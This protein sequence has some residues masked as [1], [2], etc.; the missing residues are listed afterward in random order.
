M[1]RT[2]LAQP[3]RFFAL[4]AMC[5][6]LVGGACASD[7]KADK[8]RPEG[9]FSPRA[10]VDTLRVL[11]LSDPESDLLPHG[12]AEGG[13]YGGI[14]RTSALLKALR[15]RRGVP[16]LGLS[17]GDMYMPAPELSVDSGGQNAVAAANNS[18]GIEASALGNHEFDLGESFL[19]GM[20]KAA[21][22]TYLSST[23]DVRGGALASLYVADP[24]AHSPWLADH[25]GHI[26]P[27]GLACAGGDLTAGP[28]GKKAC[29]GLTVGVVGATTE[30]LRRLSKIS[31]DI[32]VPDDRAGVVARIQAAT[33]Q[34]TAQGA[35]IVVLLSHMQ[36]VRID[37]ELAKSLTG[38]DIIVSGGGDH[39]LAD[40]DDRLLPQHDPDP[41]CADH[42]D[43]CFP[44]I[45]QAQDG[46]PVLVVATDGQYRYL[47]QLVA[48]FDDKGVLT[49]FEANNSRP[50]PIDDTS[51]AELSAAPVA[52]AAALEL[53]VQ[54]T[55]AP[56]ME[57]LAQ[58]AH[59][60]DGTREAVRNHET[61]LGNL[62]ADAMLW[63]AQ[64]AAPDIN[65]PLAVRNGGGIR[66]PI[67]S[68][69]KHS[70]E[71]QGG[72]IRE[73][74]L[75]SAFRFDNPIVVAMTTHRGLRD[76]LEAA[77]IEVGQTR[78]QFP[79]VSD[80][81]RLTYD[82]QGLNQTHVVKDG[83]IEKVQCPGT[84]I[85]DLVVT[86]TSGAPVDIVREGKLLT[87]DAPIAV[88]TLAYLAG[89]GDG[90]FPS[91][92]PDV[93]ALGETPPTEQSSVRDFVTAEAA[94]DQWHD[95]ARYAP[96]DPAQP[97]RLRPHG[98]AA[99]PPPAC[100]PAT[101]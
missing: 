15:A 80:S 36:N 62:S 87:P 18:L 66:A 84:H 56:L 91:G 100:A 31:D 3:A 89:G 79:Q 14:A 33:A 63:A 74:D 75:R 57:P 67:G 6:T 22:F 60:L 26:L 94:A 21:Q 9:W 30:Q 38:V 98:T 25:K 61:N 65:I 88:A 7:G 72:A 28:D 43:S 4:L 29:S 34:V 44:L 45:A 69:D 92:K 59:F 10:S 81:V 1:A 97:T 53:D 27:W 24:A 78:G 93:R 42:V 13:M 83:R 48:G 23:I 16:T 95:G 54:N 86:L 37:L 32:A 96:V 101:P 55:L 47:G 5:T 20:V 70:F 77:L 73:L 71:R 90:Y 82:P 64:K 40:A 8:P 39:R 35:R 46:N 58:S 49:G 17:G 2:T 52:D 12:T 50:V 41:L 19:A 11:S 99:A 76:T 68:V 51:V 85:V